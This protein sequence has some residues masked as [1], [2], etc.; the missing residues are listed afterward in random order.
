MNLYGKGDF[1]HQ[2]TKDMCV[3]G[4]TQIMMN[5]IDTGRP[6][7]SVAYQKQLYER[8][9]KLSRGVLNHGMLQLAN[10]RDPTGHEHA[11]VRR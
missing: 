2:A 1:M 10:D 6:N 3:A 9:R 7:R 11:V 8:G 4:S 5:I